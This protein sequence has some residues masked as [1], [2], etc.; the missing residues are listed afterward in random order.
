M[1]GFVY[2]VASYFN[3]PVSP[4][5]NS[6]YNPWNTLKNIARK[7]DFVAVKLDIDSP[8]VEWK[9][10]EQLFEDVELQGLIDEFFFEHHVL[11]NPAVPLGWHMSPGMDQTTAQSYKVFLKLREK[12]IRAHAWV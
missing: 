11:E 9:L 10:I 3:I 5:K 6:K 7:E 1:P 12:G 4:D 2:D 8:K